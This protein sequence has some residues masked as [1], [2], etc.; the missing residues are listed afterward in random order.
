LDP[1]IDTEKFTADLQ[2][3]VLTVT[4]PKDVKR[5]EETIKRI[6]VNVVEAE[7]VKVTEATTTTTTTETAPSEE[8]HDV[9]ASSISPEAEAPATDED[10]Q[11]LDDA[12]TE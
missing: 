9:E 2:N 1:T 12:T 6:P 10:V 7:E 4:A 3:G 5:I 11:D 8:V